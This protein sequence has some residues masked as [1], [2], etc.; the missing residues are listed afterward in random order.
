MPV[1]NAVA[2]M[3]LRQSRRGA[4]GW[5]A[6]FAGLTLLY[7]S[8]YKS[9]AQAKSAAINDYPESLKKA[10]NL[11]DFT[12]PVGY[13][14][15]TA[16]GIP[17]LLLTTVLVITMATRALA[18]DEESGAMELILSY[19]LS[20]A[21][22]VLGRMAAMVST[23]VGVAVVLTIV[24]LAAAHPVGLSIG[25]ADVLAATFTWL[26]LA[27]CLG[28]LAL[29]ASAAFGRRSTTTAVAGGAAVVAYLAASFLPLVDGLGWLRLLSPYNWFIAGNPLGKG[30]NA[31]Y[32]ALLLGTTVVATYLAELVLDRRDINT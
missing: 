18:A 20:R 6:G 24:T 4:V 10:L 30:L 15:A 2:R 23:L 27:C 8:S 7:I 32:V 14:N 26:L 9:V 3:T 29:L 22:L 28:S 11:Q 1:A 21:N 13:L 17:L 25:V 19:P 16:F 31:G 12:S 5:L